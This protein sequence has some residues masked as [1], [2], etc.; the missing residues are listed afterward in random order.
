MNKVHSKHRFIL[1]GTP[2]Q[3]NLH[4]LF[5]L[6]AF[7]HPAQARKFLQASGFIDSKSVAPD[8]VIRYVKQ[9]LV[10]LDCFI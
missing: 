1:T 6:L 10:L 9:V 5:V 2:I 8:S 4:E 3:N 7:L